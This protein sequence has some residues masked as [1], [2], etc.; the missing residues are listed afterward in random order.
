MGL[1]KELPRG[2]DVFHCVNC[3]IH[4][5]TGRWDFTTCYG[6]GEAC[7]KGNITR[8]ERNKWL[9]LKRLG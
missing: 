2:L 1:K 4:R 5:A 7:L 9:V 6:N 3:E 8:Q